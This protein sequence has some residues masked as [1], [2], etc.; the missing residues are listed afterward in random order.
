MPHIAFIHS[1]GGMIFTRLPLVRSKGGAGII[2]V[3]GIKF[4]QK[5]K[6]MVFR[7]V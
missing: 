1:Q 3:I 5:G 4:Q 2:G 7:R 6:G